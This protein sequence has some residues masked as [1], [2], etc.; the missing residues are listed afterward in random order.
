MS[1]R[2]SKYVASFDYFDIIFLSGTSGSTSIA[3]FAT[4]IGTPAGIARAS[5][6]LI[7]STGLVKNY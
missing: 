2:V 6:S 7:L 3:S 1:K 5:L 4:V